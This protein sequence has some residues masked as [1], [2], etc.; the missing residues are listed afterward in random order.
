MRS[1]I[2][3]LFVLVTLVLPIAASAGGRF[4]G[5]GAQHGHMAAAGSRG[6]MGATGVPANRHRDEPGSGGS[7]RIGRNATS[8]VR[9][10]CAF[11]RRVV[12]AF[13]LVEWYVR[14][15]GWFI[16]AAFLQR[17][18]LRRLLPIHALRRCPC[19]PRLGDG[20]ALGAA[21]RVDGVGDGG[22]EASGVEGRFRTS[23]PGGSRSPETISARAIGMRW[24]PLSFSALGRVR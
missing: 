20:R 5:R 17:G 2:T 1:T 6:R 24:L 11:V 9:L 22:A 12:V 15:R 14:R 7:R 4:L 23:C 19:L 8:A 16:S 21:D 3:A 18:P 13:K 10:W